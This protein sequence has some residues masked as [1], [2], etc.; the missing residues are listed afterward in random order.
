MYIYE[1]SVEKGL[2]WGIMSGI[3]IIWIEVIFK[4]VNFYGLIR[5]YLEI[6]D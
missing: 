4:V 6:K 3:V 2:F 1:S 5:E